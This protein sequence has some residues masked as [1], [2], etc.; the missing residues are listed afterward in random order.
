M[1]LWYKSWQAIELD[2]TK[3]GWRSYNHGQDLCAKGEREREE[4][5]LAHVTV[6]LPDLPP[7]PLPRRALGGTL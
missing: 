1:T 7:P 6:Y 2:V 4:G 5:L 3:F